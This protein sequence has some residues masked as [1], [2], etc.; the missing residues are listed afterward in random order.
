MQIGVVLLGLHGQL[1]ELV[2]Q[3]LDELV[4]QALDGLLRTLN[5][6][7]TLLLCFLLTFTKMSLTDISKVRHGN[8]TICIIELR[9]WS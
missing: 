4:L 5:V 2:L 6:K 7:P 1:V 3:A 8:V 9:N